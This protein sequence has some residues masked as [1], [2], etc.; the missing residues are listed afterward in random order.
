M[1]R[2]PVFLRY[3]PFLCLFLVIVSPV[4]SDLTFKL[5]PVLLEES[6]QSG[7]PHYW[8]TSSQHFRMQRNQ[9]GISITEDQQEKFEQLVTAE[10][11]KYESS[12]VFRGVAAFGGNSYPFVLDSGDLENEGFDILYFDFNGNGDLTDEKPVEARPKRQQYGGGYNNREFPQVEIKIATETDSYPYSFQCRAYS[13][14]SS[15][16]GLN[17]A[18]INFQSAAAREAEVEID[19][20]KHKIALL[21]FNGNGSFDNESSIPHFPRE[22]VREMYIS[23]GDILLV[24]PGSDELYFGYYLSDSAE[25]RPVSDL[26]QIDGKYYTVQI[27]RSGLEMTLKPAGVPT[28]FIQV[29]HDHFRAVIYSAENGVLN[30]SGKAGQK[31][32]IPVGEWKL[33]SYRIIKDTAASV[34]GSSQRRPITTLAC[35]ATSNYEAIQV[36]KDKTIELPFGPPIR[37]EA[38]VRQVFERNNEQYAYLN[39]EIKD[40]LGASCYDVVVNG[41]RPEAPTFVIA[42]TKGKIIERGNFEYG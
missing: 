18:G 40:A 38:Q 36:E 41:E 17:Y 32:P 26:V 25:K 35:R 19:G 22:Q 29:P 1:Q 31:V 34:D 14:Y 5:E 6:G 27:A 33:A 37:P 10:P 20:K 8:M 21:D 15:G 9:A 23:P 39:L 16:E 3:C 24:D 30:I 2:L 11:E 13:N 28:G 12:Q 4:F 42:S 7:H